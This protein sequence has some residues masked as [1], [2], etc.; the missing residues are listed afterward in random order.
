MLPIPAR[1]YSKDLVKAIFHLP[2][3][4]LKMFQALFNLK[5]ADDKFIHTKHSHADVDHSVF[6]KIGD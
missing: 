2:N 5:G 4:I 1:F 6:K 3:A